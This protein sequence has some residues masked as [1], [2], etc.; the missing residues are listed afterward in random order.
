MTPGLRY[1]RGTTDTLG[2]SSYTSSTTRLT[3]AARYL[4]NRNVTLACNLLRDS[5]AAIAS[6][7]V[8][9]CSG[10]FVWR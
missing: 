8:Y 9:G 7:T 4:F 10:E 5:G 6:A 3:L 1:I 2:G